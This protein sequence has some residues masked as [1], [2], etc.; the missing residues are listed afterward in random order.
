[1][2]VYD[3]AGESVCIVN[4]EGN[5]YA[6]GNI[7]THQGGPL[8]EGSIE[9]YDVECPWHGSKF[10]VRSGKVTEPPAEIPVQSYEVKNEDGNIL[11]RK[12]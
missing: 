8:N 2:K 11:I 10:D 6:I 12:N 4:T 3:L 5:Y 9:G 1:M 7:C